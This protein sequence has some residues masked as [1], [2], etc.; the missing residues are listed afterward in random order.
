MKK[1]KS[2][3]VIGR[4]WF[5]SVN[6]NTYHSAEV[7]VNNEFYKNI[8]C[9][10]GYGDMYIQSAYELLINDNILKDV[11]KYENGSNEVFWCYCDKKN[12]TLI[13]SVSDVKRK[14]DL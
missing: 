3:T 4:R 14:K 10:Y 2:L 5:D 9:K 11:K 13:N 7:Y 6:G 12:I 8:D 1:I